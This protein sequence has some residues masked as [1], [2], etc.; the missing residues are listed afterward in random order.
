MH[1]CEGEVDDGC[2]ASALSCRPSLSSLWSCNTPL[3]FNAGEMT[4]GER[5]HARMARDEEPRPKYT[6]ALS[7]VGVCARP[8]QERRSG[9]KSGTKELPALS[10][11][12]NWLASCLRHV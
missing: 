7:T 6:L 10:L 8:L 9:V 5:H 2:S 4:P 3:P 1:A 12:V 11:S